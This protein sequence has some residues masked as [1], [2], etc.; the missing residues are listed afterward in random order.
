MFCEIIVDTNNGKNSEHSM[1]LPNDITNKLFSSI[2]FLYKYNRS[3]VYYIIVIKT[4]INENCF[5][6][7]KKKK[8]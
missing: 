1:I 5:K 4:Q 7:S 8:G 6:M 2:R 3:N